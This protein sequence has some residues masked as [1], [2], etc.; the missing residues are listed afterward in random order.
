MNKNKELVEEEERKKE[1][2][3][4]KS[5]V[6][7]LVFSNLITFSRT[8][9]S[10]GFYPSVLLFWGTTPICTGGH[11]K[12]ALALTNKYYRRSTTVLLDTH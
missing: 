5:K 8:M 12:H 6:S 10:V 2:R 11:L 9:Q 4:A 7:S 1:R 3:R